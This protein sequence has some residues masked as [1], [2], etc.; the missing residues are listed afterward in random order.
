MTKQIIHPYHQDEFEYHGNTS[1]EHKRKQAG[2]TTRR[3]IIF[4]SVEEAQAYFNDNCD[5]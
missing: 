2:K 3:W 1:I 5:T 4:D